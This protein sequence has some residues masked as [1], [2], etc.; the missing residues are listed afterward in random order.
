MSCLNISSARIN[1]IFYY[2]GKVYEAKKKIQDKLI[3]HIFGKPH[4]NYC[5]INVTGS[6]DP[7]GSKLFRELLFSIDGE[8][9]PRVFFNLQTNG[10]MF[11]PRYWDKI[12]RI[13]KKFEKKSTLPAHRAYPNNRY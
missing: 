13:Q 4:D 10:V 11:T 8:K 5:L 3:A 9:F 12:K 2:E 6:G 7:F 1:K